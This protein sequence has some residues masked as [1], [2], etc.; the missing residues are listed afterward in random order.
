MAANTRR[1]VLIIIRA[2]TAAGVYVYFV[3]AAMSS[4][5]RHCWPIT[6]SHDGRIAR[7][8]WRPRHMLGANDERASDAPNRAINTFCFAAAAVG[9]TGH[10]PRISF[11]DYAITKMYCRVLV[12]FELGAIVL[13]ASSRMTNTSG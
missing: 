3:A 8:T 2:I 9:I 11:E 13:H 4:P 12:Y 7:C 5:G 1:D 10:R 6:D